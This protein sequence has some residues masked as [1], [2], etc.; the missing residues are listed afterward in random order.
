MGEWLGG[1]FQWR[2][3]GNRVGARRG[4]Q[5]PFDFPT[6]KSWDLPYLWRCGLEA[7]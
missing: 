6:L 1:D 4:W 2:G 5:R 7:I 3:L